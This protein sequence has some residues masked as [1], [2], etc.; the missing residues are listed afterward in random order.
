MRDGS[1]NDEGLRQQ[2]VL[3]LSKLACVA[4]MLPNVGS[5]F[6]T[7]PAQDQHRLLLVF[8]IL[9]P[10]DDRAGVDDQD[11]SPLSSSES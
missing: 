9:M 7:N 10:A 8:I 5:L 1:A 4:C 3:L 6:E 2:L 11:S